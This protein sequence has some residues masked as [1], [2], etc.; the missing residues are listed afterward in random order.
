MRT[1]RYF[2]VAVISFL[3]FTLSGS[4]LTLGK[5]RF[6]LAFAAAEQ[7]LES[8]GP[9]TMQAANDP[10]EQFNRGVFEF[11]DRLYFYVLKPTTV[12]YSVILPKG[13]REAIQNGYHNAVSPSRF[14]NFMLQGK[15]DKATNETMRFLINSTIGVAGLFDLAR[16]Q[17]GL[18]NHEADFG[19]T[20][21]LWGVGPGD[22]MMVPVLGPSDPRDLFGY[23]VDSV[24]NPLFW[25]PVDW[26]VSASIGAGNFENHAS[27]HLGEYEDLKKASLDPYVGMRDAYIQY[28]EH[29]VSK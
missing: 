26:W 27:L 18:E 13:L 11:N 23:G 10:H 19:Q 5:W 21:A 14:I 20:L 25:L 4:P 6:N 2:E 24:M 1:C 28:R 3:I 22:F 16:T 12:V 15:A 17:F 9:P 7:D 8:E 29:L